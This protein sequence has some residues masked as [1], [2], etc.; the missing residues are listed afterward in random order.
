MLRVSENK[1][2]LS[3]WSESAEDFAVTSFPE[4]TC[5]THGSRRCSSSRGEQLWSEKEGHKEES[6]NGVSL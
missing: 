3:G 5:W 4:G 6:E 1:A 2:L